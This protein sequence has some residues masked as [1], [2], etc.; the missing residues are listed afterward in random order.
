MML[1]MAAIKKSGVSIIP[2][3]LMTVGIIALLPNGIRLPMSPSMM[4]FP[5]R[6][7]DWYTDTLADLLANAAVGDLRPAIAAEI[8]MRDAARA[9]AMLEEGGLVGKVVLTNSG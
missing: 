3:S 7:P 4:N 1:G 9:H 6:N 2:L 8:P 5:A